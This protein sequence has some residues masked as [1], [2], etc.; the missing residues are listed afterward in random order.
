MLGSLDMPINH[1]RYIPSLAQD[2]K[3]TITWVSGNTVTVTN[4]K[5]TTRS[6]VV[7][8]PISQPAGRWF[9]TVAAGSFI[10][11]SSDAEVNATFKYL[12]L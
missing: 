6:V 9:V 4:G 1:E 12:L 8:M 2:D 11:T 10:V 3:A 5:I 7:I